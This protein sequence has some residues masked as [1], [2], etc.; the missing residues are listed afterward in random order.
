M[1]YEGRHME[2]SSVSDDTMRFFEENE[3]KNKSLIGVD[4][5]RLLI[6]D[7]EDLNIIMDD[8][9]LPWIPV[10]I[11]VPHNDIFEEAN[12]LLYTSCYTMHR[13]NSS[14]WMSLCIHGMSSVHTNVPED[15]G[16]PDEAEYELSDWTDI[17]KF[18]PKTKQWLMDEVRYSPFSRVRFMAVLPGGWLGPHRDTDRI[19]GVGATNVAINNP[20]GCALV[21]EDWGTMPFTPGSM[22]KINTGYQHA[23]WNRSEEPRIHMILDGDPSDYF[24]H[25]VNAG[26]VN[27]MKENN[28]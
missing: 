28:A 11:S 1:W 16:L 27:L 12:H 21:M 9:Y 4:D 23:V 7:D 24:K 5:E 17:A 3:H 25:K 6:L 13:P 22:F 8:T 20:D 2:Q 19:R 15:Y 26:Y 10:P 14:G 18:A